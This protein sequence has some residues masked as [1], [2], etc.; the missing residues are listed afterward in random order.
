MQL[1]PIV[2]EPP[3]FAGYQYCS[4][5]SI[6]FKNPTSITITIIII[7][8]PME[9][10]QSAPAAFWVVIKWID[11]H[12]VVLKFSYYSILFPWFLKSRISILSGSKI[13]HNTRL[14]RG[15]SIDSVRRLHTYWSS[16]VPISRCPVSNRNTGSA[17]VASWGLATRKFA[18]HPEVQQVASQRPIY[19]FTAG[20]PA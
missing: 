3:P 13:F 16:L 1:P 9:H 11:W 6:H 7:I 15:T 14:Q 2:Q 19:S 20:W 4:P 12:S 18:C 8:P 10:L 17:P 5:P